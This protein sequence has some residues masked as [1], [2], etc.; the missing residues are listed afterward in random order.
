MTRAFSFD[1]D[2]P[3]R[4]TAAVLAGYLKVREA[5]EDRGFDDDATEDRSS[6]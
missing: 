4:R 1:R 3:P 6:R 2:P 5:R